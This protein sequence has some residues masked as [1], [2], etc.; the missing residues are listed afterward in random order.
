MPRGG[1]R[2]G[3]GRKTAWM[4]GCSFE[5]TTVIRVPKYLKSKILELAHRLD[6]GEKIDLDTKSIKEKNDRLENRILELEKQLLNQKEFKKE[7]VTKP[8]PQESIKFEQQLID[9]DTNSKIILSGQKL[10]TLRFGLSRNAATKQKSRISKAKFAIWSR[11]KDPDN[12]AWIPCEKGYTP[13]DELSDDLLKNLKEWI[14][15]NR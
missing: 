5:E 4:S 2:E 14:A 3:A 12:I 9:L 7:I 1:K 13:Q 11:S 6:A 10:S 8:K 15:N